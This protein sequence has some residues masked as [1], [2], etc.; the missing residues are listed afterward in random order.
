MSLI[1]EG[2]HRGST[3][4]AAGNLWIHGN[5]LSV[6]HG[7]RLLQLASISILAGRKQV[8]NLLFNTQRECCD[9]YVNQPPR[10]R[11]LNA[12]RTSRGGFQDGKS[13]CEIM[14]RTHIVS[15][16]VISTETGRC[17]CHQIRSWGNLLGDTAGFCRSKMI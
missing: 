6:F 1:W 14:Q 5:A 17:S 13:D 16:E 7:R 3:W 11:D 4:M 2:N 10:Q 9:S 15:E 8:P 12:N